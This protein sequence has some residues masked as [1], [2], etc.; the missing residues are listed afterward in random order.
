MNLSAQCSKRRCRSW[1]RTCSLPAAA[2]SLCC[3]AIAAFAQEP[4]SRPAAPPTVISEKVVCKP[5][6]L[7]PR[8]LEEFRVRTF[9]NGVVVTS[10]TGKS[11]CRRSSPQPPVRL[12]PSVQ[13]VL[14]QQMRRVSVLACQRGSPVRVTPGGQ[15]LS[16]VRL[17]DAGPC[18]S[19]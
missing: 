1:F 18:R 10:G 7:A 17:Q 14:A 5:S 6:P 9:S 4:R 2:S 16:A 12:L 15:V 19:N 8:R 11:P 13:S 3:W